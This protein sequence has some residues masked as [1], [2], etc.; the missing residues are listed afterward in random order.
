M[1]Q[2]LRRSGPII[3][4]LCLRYY[5]GR[6]SCFVVCVRVCWGGGLPCRDN[7][8]HN[9]LVNILVFPSPTGYMLIYLILIFFYMNNGL[10]Y[11]FI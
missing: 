4:Q 6:R 7:F 3:F 10:L 8:G 5:V 1:V 9:C 11:K 2:L